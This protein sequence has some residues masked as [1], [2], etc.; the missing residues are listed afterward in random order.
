MDGQKQIVNDIHPNVAVI[1]SRQLGLSEISVATMLWFADTHSYAGVNCLYT[2]PTYKSMQDFIK[3]R[4]NPVL[5]S[6]PYYHSIIDANNNS[7]DSKRIR[8]S[9][10]T[11]RTSSKPGAVEGIKVCPLAG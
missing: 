11:F 6:T 9:F 2:F 4:L 3:M 8:N 5:D 1:K 7:I 10:L